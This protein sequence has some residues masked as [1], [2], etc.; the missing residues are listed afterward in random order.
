MH[1]KLRLLLACVLVTLLSL[2]QRS[3]SQVFNKSKV[4]LLPVTPTY[5]A[6]GD[7]NG[8][9]KADLVYQFTTGTSPNQTTTNQV[10]LNNGDGTFTAGQALSFAGVA[11][12]RTFVA[13]INGD[14]IPDLAVIDSNYTAVPPLTLR[15][16]LGKGDGT[17]GAPVITTLS[18]GPSLDRDM[19][20]ADFNG[21]GKL[22]LA[23][24]TSQNIYILNGTGTGA[25]VLSSVQ[26]AAQSTNVLMAADFNGDGRPDLV[27]FDSNYYAHVFL[28]SAS[29]TFSTT[30]AAYHPTAAIW[31][32]GVGDWDN[33]GHPDLLFTDYAGN[34]Y[35]AAARSD[36]TF[37]AVT[38]VGTFPNF[39]GPYLQGTADLHGDGKTRVFA[40]NALG[41]GVIGGATPAGTPAV[42]GAL[43]STHTNFAPQ[44]LGLLADFTGDGIIDIAFLADNA[45][46]VI[47]GNADGTLSSGTTVPVSAFEGVAGVQLSD[48]TGD[49]IPDALVAT[50]GIL[51]GNG[52]GT[53]TALPSNYFTNQRTLLR[54]DLDGDGKT[55]FLDTGSQT[56]YYG[57]GSGT[58][59]SLQP[60]L[61]TTPSTQTT[62]VYAFGDF[63]HD[64]KLGIAAARFDYISTF[65]VSFSTAGATPRA[66]NT[67]F[68]PATEHIFALASGD[69]NGDGC[70]DVV[71]AGQT[72]ILVFLSDCHGGFTQ[73][74]SYLTG[75]TGLPYHDAFV[76]TDNILDMALVDLDGDGKLDLVAP[77][78]AENLFLVFYGNGD[79]T[80]T[81]GAS[82]TIP[83]SQFITAADLDNDG[84]AELIFTGHG[85]M[86]IYPGTTGRNHFLAPTYYPAGYET[87]KAAVGDT[88]RR[89]RLDIAVPNLGTEGNLGNQQGYS[90]TMFLNPLPSLATNLLNAK[91]VATPE[92]SALGQ[93]FTLTATFTPANNTAVPTGNITFKIDNTTLGTAPLNASG[94]AT[95]SVTAAPAAGTHSI[96][97]A[98]PGDANFLNITATGTHV[99]TAAATTSTLSVAP[100]APVYGDTLSVTAKVVPTL[101]STLTPTGT[102][103]FYLDGVASAPATLPA[104][105]I[106]TI[107]YQY[108]AAGSGNHTVGCTY[109]GDTNFTASTCA[110]KPVTVAQQPVQATLLAPDP[111]TAGQPYRLLVT[112][113]Y[114][115]PTTTSGTITISDGATILATSPL[116]NNFQSQVL[117]IPALAAG[118]HN[119]SCTYS[120]DSNHPA[121][122]CNPFSVNANATTTT[123]ITSSLNPSPVGS[124]VTFI[125]EVS[126]DPNA[127][128]GTVA[129]SVTFSD[130]GTPLATLPFG[131]IGCANCTPGTRGVSFSTST[132][133]VGSHTITATFIPAGNF[134]TS[135]A[136]LTQV[137]YT[138]IAVTARVTSS[139]NPSYITQPVTFTAEARQQGPSGL[140]AP[141]SVTFFDGTT[142]LYTDNNFNGVT[143]FTT[144]A[145]SVG[146]HN[147]NIAY[148]PAT[149][150]AAATAALSQVVKL[151]DT[152]TT[153][154]VNYPTTYGFASTLTA[155]VSPAITLSTP[156]T[157][158][159][160]FTFDGKAQPAIA[161]TPAGLATL[162][163]NFNAGT[164]TI[165]CVYTGD[166]SYSGSS[167]GNIITITVVP[168]AT[169]LTLSTSGTP[170]LAGSNV[171]FTTHLTSNGAPLPNTAFT[172]S[173]AGTQ[174]PI[175]TDSSGNATYST[176]TLAPGTYAVAV[177]YAGDANHVSSTAS[178]TQIIAT[179]PV[180]ATFTAS[181]N[182]AYQ[183]QLVT[184]TATVTSMNSV[185]P[186]GTVNFLDNGQL[187]S[188]VAVD[189][190]GHATF[191]TST[192]TVGDHPLSVS[193]TPGSTSFSTALAATK[194]ETILPSAFT[195][196]LSPN[197]LILAPGAAGSTTLQLT[198]VG[199]FAGPLTFSVG[200]V[201]NYAT[202][203]FSAPTATLAA[204]GTASA[205]LNIT[206]LVLAQNTAPRNTPRTPLLFTAL[207][208]LA[209]PLLRRRK[210]LAQL[211]L[212]LFAIAALQFTTGC[213]NDY[214][215]PN[216]V[217]PGT[218][219]VPVTATDTNHVQQT[220]TLTIV[221][222]S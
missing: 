221:V 17:F 24:A 64:G 77:V 199:A 122:N 179:D 95:L 187:L 57:L 219:S 112:L 69:L 2:A 156:P 216:H 114:N 186:V 144:S 1:P 104:S 169:S 23:F 108:Q 113:Y 154:N 40:S 33:D 85:L 32:V 3:S 46:A 18:N 86:T 200:T 61:T 16:Y 128:A 66:F 220:A 127:N 98:F 118:S 62:G 38:Q 183:S 71:A 176:N 191:T 14:G 218:Y 168:A 94:V 50:D 36:G 34:L 59:T 137:V 29:G 9:G 190:T 100:S 25:F 63:K 106:A 12:G 22:D 138:V 45:I 82:Q 160:I 53:F 44:A 172:L 125:A 41:I 188:S 109:S 47:P 42:A 196:A 88:R 84:H 97:A 214:Y 166:T 115:G 148:T 26:L 81:Q 161:I 20:F 74:A 27:S 80:F 92:P 49:G 202:A 194:I 60:P 180:T 51:Q 181:P 141:G 73:V 4:T 116:V 175:T 31:S 93:T 78:S 11:D 136:S 6:A 133:A 48:V 135:S 7:F 131:Q 222:K 76:P 139:L 157:G 13:D 21:D 189:S 167:C 171:T 79:G 198:S 130:N 178:L 211:A 158:S 35:T 204:G 207:T 208:L 173:I 205:T 193:F 155:T 132:L 96:S 117:T 65:G 8:D 75:F 72:H 102:V 124:N 146:S 87:G 121:A 149:G 192:L 153:L 147:I 55:D 152:G 99:V 195:L 67:T 120:G 145:L 83:S 39:T 19:V 103:T 209:L 107:T 70:A 101:A 206:T 210:R 52:D 140:L 163:F 151:V 201:P 197:T 5:F 89:G 28:N 174:L 58:F 37:A 30:A 90:F 170:A 15:V 185:V 119:F 142:P 129:G 126:P 215:V 143:S 212:A 164:H 184:V 123:T 217:A 43:V 177:T 159:V 213:V 111:S 134:N 162:T 10:M 56:I 182:P 110:D 91:I 165:S 203:K 68:L 150:Y 105:G 54:G